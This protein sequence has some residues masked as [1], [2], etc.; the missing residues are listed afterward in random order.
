MTVTKPISSQAKRNFQTLCR[1]VK[2]DRICL[3]SV[4]DSTLGSE[5]TLICAVNYR[6]ST[7]SDNEFVPLAS[8]CEGDPY[9]RYIPPTAECEAFQ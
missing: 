3:M 5:T 1:A 4:F 2:A 8:M 6:P 9:T 7:E